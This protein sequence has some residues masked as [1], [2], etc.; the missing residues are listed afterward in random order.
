MAHCVVEIISDYM[1]YICYIYY[2]ISMLYNTVGIM[3]FEEMKNPINIL[4]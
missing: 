2:M 3:G 1:C 4:F